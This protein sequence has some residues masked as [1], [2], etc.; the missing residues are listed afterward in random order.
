MWF[1]PCDALLD[2]QRRCSS[3]RRRVGLDLRHQVKYYKSKRIQLKARSDALDGAVVSTEV[4]VN[5]QH[6][7]LDCCT[8]TGTP[9]FGT[10]SLYF[11]LG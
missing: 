2:W 7:M 4:L 5:T 1:D 11:R 9:A 8:G 10:K 3:I 6:T